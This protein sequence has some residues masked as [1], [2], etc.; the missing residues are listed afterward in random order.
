M[1]PVTVVEVRNP[2]GDLVQRSIVR[3]A[4]FSIGRS[5]T[6][7][8]M[9][10]DEYL[11]GRHA[12]VSLDD[13]GERITV[14]DLATTN[15]TRVDGTLIRDGSTVVDRATPITLG[16]S[17][18]TLHRADAEVAP[19]RPMARTTEDT[20]RFFAYEGWPSWLLFAA[21]VAVATGGV[22]LVS[23]DTGEPAFL[24]A[25]AVFFAVMVL[26]WAG[27]WALGTKVATR[28]SRFREHLAFASV[29]ILV[30]APLGAALE[31]LAFM[32]SSAAFDTVVGLLTGWLVWAVAV[33][34]HLDIASSR[35]RFFKGA[36]ATGVATGLV[37][38]GL[39]V[40]QVGQ[41]PTTAIN[42]SLR[43]I[44]PVPPALTRST[45]P[46]DFLQGLP[47]LEEALIQD[48]EEALEERPYPD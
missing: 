24:V 12:L 9:L 11:D 13:D 46:E 4:E 30:G 31:W 44:L 39:L 15:G 7:Q 10:D 37:G 40:A 36:W 32:A 6:N 18:V 1:E 5:A 17:V 43:Q 21:S 45:S 2:S 47:D 25:L 22:W 23:Y 26:F 48:A 19:A 33:A 35:S 27:L 3:G 8:V 14:R 28:S 34:G 16:E 38:L 42:Q 41:G 29:V 20:G